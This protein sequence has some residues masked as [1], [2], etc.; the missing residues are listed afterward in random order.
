MDY[1]RGIGESMWGMAVGF[2]ALALFTAPAAAVFHGDC[3]RNGEVAISEVQLCANL[4]LEVQAR[5][6]CVECDRDGDGAVGIAEVQGVANCFLDDPGCVMLPSPTPTTTANVPTSTPALTPVPSSTSSSTSTRTSTRTPTR[7]ATRTPTRTSTRSPTGTPTF[8]STRTS[9]P[10]PSRTATSTPSRTQ[11]PISTPTT[12]GSPTPTEQV[13]TRVVAGDCRVPGPGGLVAAPA[14]TKVSVYRCGA[15]LRACTADPESATFLGQATVQTG[16]FFA[17]EVRAPFGADLLYVADLPGVVYRFYGVFDPGPAGSTTG[18]SA[19]TI[20]EVVIDPSS[21]GATRQFDASMDVTAERLVTLTEETRVRSEGGEAYADLTLNDAARQGRDFA[22]CIVVENSS[23]TCN[24]PFNFIDP[25][26]SYELFATSRIRFA[27]C[28]GEGITYG[29]FGFHLDCSE[30]IPCVD[31]G[32]VITFA[33]NVSSNCPGGVAV[34]P[35]PQND[36][37]VRAPAGLRLNPGAACSIEF[38]VFV[39]SLSNDESPTQV[40]YELFFT[41]FCDNGLSAANLS[42]YFSTIAV[43]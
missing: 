3:N 18:T 9:T 1:L 16:G 12:T 30:T 7:T 5:D 29:P 38:D 43:P 2:A 21:E 39:A 15:N 33:G 13:V 10:T 41:G 6:G 37:V 34:A 4:Y 32:E 24:L 31:D 25:I 19:G 20:T 36:N 26:P 23:M 27:V 22:S 42:A 40:E 14:G 8:T 35:D 28:G 17:L 11:T